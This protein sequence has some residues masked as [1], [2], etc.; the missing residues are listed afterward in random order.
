MEVLLEKLLQSNLFCI[1]F[2]N[3]LGGIVFQYVAELHSV[4]L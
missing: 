2:P 3:G 1:L 4:R